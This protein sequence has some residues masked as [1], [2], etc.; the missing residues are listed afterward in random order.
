MRSIIFRSTRVI[1][2]RTLNILPVKLLIL[3]L[4]LCCFNDITFQAFPLHWRRSSSIDKWIVFQEKKKLLNWYNHTS[5]QFSIG[6]PSLSL[7]LSLSLSYI[8]HYDNRVN[9]LFARCRLSSFARLRE[10]NYNIIFLCNT[11]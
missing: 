10:Y 9:F 2:I 4:I 6:T 8:R 5:E 3:Q 7:S 11:K 1:S